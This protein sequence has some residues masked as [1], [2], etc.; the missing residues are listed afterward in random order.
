MWRR[1]ELRQFK[2][3]CIGSWKGS[4]RLW[5]PSFARSWVQLDGRIHLYG[6][7]RCFAFFAGRMV[8]RFGIWKTRKRSTADDMR[9]SFTV[10]WSTGFIS[11]PPNLRAVSSPWRTGPKRWKSPAKPC[12]RPFGRLEEN[13]RSGQGE[14]V[15]TALADFFDL[16]GQNHEE[17]FAGV[18]NAWEVLPR[19]GDYLKKN[20]R[21][22]SKAKLIGAPVIGEN[23]HLGEL[24]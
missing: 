20:L 24:S 12:G 1:T 3:K 9:G 13:A 8:G 19:I 16:Q 7:D 10:F 15:N 17:L 2:F 6:S 14:R 5:K 21:N 22:G 23:V 4:A 18:K 11:R